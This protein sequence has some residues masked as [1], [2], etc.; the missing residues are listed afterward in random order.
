MATGKRTVQAAESP[1]APGAALRKQVGLSGRRAR[2]L[3]STALPTGGT[4]SVPENV[5]AAEQAPAPVSRR[6]GGSGHGRWDVKAEV[7]ALD[8]AE[9]A[10]FDATRAARLFG[11]AV[12]NLRTAKGWSQ[13]KLADAAGMKQQSVS[14]IEESAS[15]LPT[16]AVIAKLARALDA[17]A[18]VRVRT[19]ED[20]GFEFTLT[21]H[22]G[23]A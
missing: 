9:R 22:H 13:R 21:P 1:S 12:Y 16:L 14:R 19:G 2:A 20:E 7:T 3:R 4:G 6:T 23:A 18:L 17:D 11:E 8:A 15:A 5:P 10:E